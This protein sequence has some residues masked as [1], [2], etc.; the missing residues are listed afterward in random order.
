MRYRFLYIFIAIV[1]TIFFLLFSDRQQKIQTRK[2][3][4]R[5]RTSCFAHLHTHEMCLSFSSECGMLSIFNQF[6]LPDLA[7]FVFKQT[8]YTYSAVI[9]I[10]LSLTFFP[11]FSITIVNGLKSN[12]LNYFYISFFLFCWS[13]TWEC[14]HFPLLSALFRSPF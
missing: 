12:I 1:A 2:K 9:Y 11:L 7:P 8:I 14:F 6:T 13:H 4:I 5:T 10:L 3:L